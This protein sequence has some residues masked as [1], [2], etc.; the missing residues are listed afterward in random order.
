MKNS[1]ISIYPKILFNY[2]ADNEIAGKYCVNAKAIHRFS[3]SQ[4]LKHVV[5][6]K[7]GFPEERM[8][9]VHALSVPTNGGY[10]QPKPQSLSGTVSTIVSFLTC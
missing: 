1:D 5:H 7:H 3:C 6:V 10:L 2:V 9:E 4:G 8:N